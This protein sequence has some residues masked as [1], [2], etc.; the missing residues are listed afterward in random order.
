[1]LHLAACACM[2][3]VAASPAM[4]QLRDPI[5]DDPVMSRLGL[6]VREVASFPRSA[7][8][9]APSD[10]RLMRWARI[11]HLGE[12]PD[13]SG[14]KYV[15]DLNG[16]L[17]LLRGDTPRVYLDVRS[18]IGTR[19]FSSRG[20]GSG[21]GFVAFH[22]DFRTNGR[23]YTVHTE[24]VDTLN[25]RAVDFRLQLRTGVHGVLTEWTARNPGAD[26]FAGTR[27]ELLRI[28]FATFIH[29]IQQIDFNPTAR[30]GDGDF[31]LLYIAVG[32]GGIGVFTDDPQNLS[33]PHGKLLRIDPAGR[34][35]ANGR[36]GI[37]RDNPFVGKSG[38]LAEIFAYGMRDPHRFSWDPAAPHRM[39]LA[40]IGEKSVESIHDVRAGDNLGWSRREGA[41]VFDTTHRCDLRAL[42]TDDAK[43]GYAYPVA[44]YDHDPPPGHSC[45]ADVGHAISGGYVYRGQAVP[46]LH[47]KYVFADLVDGRVMYTE[48]RDM[49]R[50]P[51]GANATIHELAIFDSTARE[52]TMPGLAGD[53]RVDLRL[54]RD[55]A[56]ELYLLSK[57]NGK[58]W[59]VVGVREVA[60][61]S[62]VFPALAPALVAHFDFEHP[63]AGD[64]S[65]EVDQGTSGTNISLVNGGSR[66]R[67]RDGAHASSSN[68]IQLRQINPDRAGND[69]W[70]AGVY[71]PTGVRTL[72]PFNGVRGATIM[73]WFKMTGTN[74]GPNSHSA[75]PA[76]RYNAVGFAGI[77]SGDSDGH[78]A[79]ALLELIVVN[80][81]MR[82]VALGRR[83]D[84]GSS[85]TFAASEKWET[86]LPP[87]VWVFL[88][89]TFNYTN[90]TMALYRNGRPLA[91]FYANA[92][93]PWGVTAADG[94]PATSPTDPRGIKIGGSFPQNTRE[95]NACNCRVDDLMF[96]NRALTPLEVNQQFRRWLAV[97]RN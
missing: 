20:L 68:S 74:P 88:A 12:I 92:N 93:D 70:K 30:A 7:P 49:R 39:F 36:Y 58:V 56:G 75:D 41:F 25:A 52:T 22:P 16:F 62:T 14:R 8:S 45:A 95:A 84:D 24:A 63:L 6:V 3:G 66:M 87:N 33:M 54:G 13:G 34:N 79:R 28:G 90:G 94:P 40:H 23:F 9:P 64:S 76:D 2:L 83:L 1:V 77:L 4:A 89:A 17:Y 82:L 57:A 35:S 86:L 73:G 69:D 29:G 18:E 97:A 51:A 78:A 47:G 42:P 71:S 27:R 59:K 31:G 96:L 65:I 32:D 60:R 19:F 61:S 46:E 67:V 21:F 15:P 91:G 48:E 81:T 11:N 72:A 38:A 55:A 5:V 80:D 50:A 26:V 44:A 43:H 37:P 10:Q 53:A 85:Q